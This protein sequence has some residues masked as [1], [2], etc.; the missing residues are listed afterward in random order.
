MQTL[1]NLTKL[2]KAERKNNPDTLNLRVH[3]AL[4]WLRHAEPVE[5][6]DSK[7]IFYWIAFNAV[8]AQD[9]EHGVR[10]A[11]KGLF[12]QF[13]HRLCALDHNKRIYQLVWRTFPNSI[14]VLLD[15]KFTFQ[16]FWDYHN[17]QLSEEEWLKQFERNKNQALQALSGQNTPVVL[18]SVFNHIYTLRNQVFHGGS[19]HLSRVNRDQLRD[20]CAIL[21]GFLSEIILIMLT[22]PMEEQ[23]GVPFYPIIK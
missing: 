8:Y 5:D 22:H 14:R 2:Y 11:D 21:G 23:W 7:F 9:F 18:T 10:G 3:R 20:A 4:S 6:L 1:E 17:N 12:V 13:I 16:P 15:N 19:T